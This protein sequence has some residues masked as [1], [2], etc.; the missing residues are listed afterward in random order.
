[1]FHCHKWDGQIECRDITLSSSEWSLHL[2]LWG[3]SDEVSAKRQLRSE[4]QLWTCLLCLEKEWIWPDNEPISSRK[5]TSS[6]WL[7]VVQLTL[8]HQFTNVESKKP[9]QIWRD[10]WEASNLRFSLSCT[11]IADSMSV[12]HCYSAIYTSG[13]CQLC[14]CFLKVWSRMSLCTWEAQLC[15]WQ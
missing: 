8:Q 11:Q 6:Y 14:Q 3:I 7:W 2:L 12:R 5:E 13:I 1:V 9:E 10:S 15:H 4:T